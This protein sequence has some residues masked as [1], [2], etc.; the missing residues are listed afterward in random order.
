[1]EKD[2]HWVVHV[3]GEIPASVRPFADVRKD[4]VNVLYGERVDAAL[5]EYVGKLR[6]AHKI[7]IFVTRM[8]T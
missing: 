7:E 4:I 1:V 3:S 6:G 5:R 8:A 2:Q